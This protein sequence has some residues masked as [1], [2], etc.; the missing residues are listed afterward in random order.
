MEEVWEAL[1][2]LDQ[3][4]Q[5]S[6][7]TQHWWVFPDLKTRKI[8]ED[9]V[10]ALVAIREAVNKAIEERRAAGELGS[11]LE[12]EVR[13][14]L[15]RETEKNLYPFLEAGELRF[16]LIVSSV[17]VLSGS[18]DLVEVKTSSQPKCD[19]CWHRLSTVGENS[20]HP[21]LCA[22]CI[23]NVQ[24]GAGERRVML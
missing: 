10:Q 13:L 22:R 1:P 3:K 20:E 24:E 18:E 16:G 23:T 17:E 5:E 21:G 15:T 11:S 8:S 4:G 14:T 19:R 7:F 2:H 6:L 12:A 9:S